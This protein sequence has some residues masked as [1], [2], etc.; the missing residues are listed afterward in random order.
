MSP[1]KV[2]H[3]VEGDPR[4]LRGATYGDLPLAQSVDCIVD[5]RFTQAALDEPAEGLRSIRLESLGEPIDFAEAL[6]R[7]A[8]RD[9]LGHV[10]DI[11][12]RIHRPFGTAIDGD[13][14]SAHGP[15]SLKEQSDIQSALAGV[16]DVGM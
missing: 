11:T 6:R 14:E 8:D 2:E 13:P 12:F 10:Y 3:L 9:G 5:A 15:L 16:Q 4:H 1:Y 7:E